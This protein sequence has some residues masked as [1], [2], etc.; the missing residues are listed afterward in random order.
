M[1]EGS[2]YICTYLLYI[3]TQIQYLNNLVSS[4]QLLR[5]VG[6][7]AGRNVRDEDSCVS[8]SPDDVEPKPLAVWVPQLH[9]TLVMGFNVSVGLW[10][11]EIVNATVRSGWQWQAVKLTKQRDRKYICAS[12]G[13]KLMTIL[14][15]IS[16]TSVRS[17]L[18]LRVWLIRA[19]QIFMYLQ[20]AYEPRSP[21]V[22]AQ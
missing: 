2:T 11:E 20:G 8:L 7:A 6:E 1:H 9:C 17:K 4:C 18:Q 15:C 10:G 22:E 3:C 16:T 12:L 21:L 13:W 14:S 5:L 19:Y